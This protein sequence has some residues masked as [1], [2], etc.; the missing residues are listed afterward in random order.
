[1]E[2]TGHCLC[3]ATQY[4]ITMGAKFGIRCYCGDC[5]RL[6]GSGSVVQFAFPEDAVKVIGPL[7]HH[8]GTADSGNVLD[9]GFCGD[10]GSP[11]VKT[12]TRAKGLIFVYAGSMENTE[13]LP[14]LSPV[15]EEARPPWYEANNS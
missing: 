3:G 1:M 14:S 8:L 13:G 6:S 4:T 5:R 15:F 11:I 12:T 7:K 10:C 2:R 9:F